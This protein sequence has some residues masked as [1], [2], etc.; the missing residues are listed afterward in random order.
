LVLNLASNNIFAKGIE[1]LAEAL[2]RNQIMTELNVSGNAATWDGKRNGEMSGVIALA[3]AIPDMRA[4]TKFDISSNKIYAEGGK[5]LAEGLKGNQVIKELNFSGNDLGYNSNN[6]TDTS[7]IIAIA[8][9]IP[10]MGALVKLG[11]AQC[12]TNVGVT[13]RA[14]AALGKALADALAANTVLQ[15]LDLSGNE[16]KPEFA[17]E[18]AVGLSKNIALSGLNLSNNKIG[19]VGAAAIRGAVKSNVRSHVYFLR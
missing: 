5:A 3:N 18:L 12:A 16:L 14:T 9:V 6:V 19:L 4:M 10:G 2:K 13:G 1:L 17:Q 8:D 11:L 7:G 15:E